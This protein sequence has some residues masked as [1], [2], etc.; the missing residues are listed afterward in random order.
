MT[1]QRRKAQKRLYRKKAKKPQT[2]HE[3]RMKGIHNANWRI[4][5]WLIC[6]LPV[7]LVFTWRSR[8]KKANKMAATVAATAG[9]T[10]LV[11]MCMGILQNQMIGDGGN[12]TASE[13]PVVR[14]YGPEI[15][16]GVGYSYVDEE[17]IQPA[18]I[19]T[20]EPTAEPETAFVNEGGD[21]FHTE[22]C[23]YFKSSSQAYYV[24]YLLEHGFE[25]HDGCLA[26]ILAEEYTGQK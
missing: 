16:D 9:W 20:P 1:E 3:Q 12:Q 11:F 13:K 10:V 19:V 4:I 17:Y 6:M 8:W 25:P 21:Y 14:G 2:A 23:Q 24:P 26:V 7:G 15:P 18:V 5:R 22:G